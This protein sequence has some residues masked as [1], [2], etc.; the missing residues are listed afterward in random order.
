METRMRRDLHPM[1]REGLRGEGDPLNISVLRFRGVGRGTN[2][3]RADNGMTEI[4]RKQLELLDRWGFTT[5]TLSDYSLFLRGDL[6][7]PRRPII[8][9]FDGL[10]LLA[11]L[12]SP[13]RDV[14]GRAMVFVSTESL[15]GYTGDRTTPNLR[16]LRD[17]GIQVG[18][19]TCSQR[20]LASLTPC[21]RA[22]ELLRSR[23]TLEDL[24]G[25]PVESCAYPF[26]VVN[27]DVKRSVLEAGYTFGLAGPRGP[28]LFGTD[29]LEIRREVIDLTTGVFNLALRVFA[30][31]DRLI[32][33]RTRTMALVAR[34][35]THRVPGSIV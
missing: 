15:E 13:L 32:R 33:L 11:P 12:V 30:P 31:T 34:E 1:D 17:I 22:E 19:L 9:T 23:E 14:G 21:E 4:F 20:E 3:H 5:I 26:D 27:A 6:H 35:S 7:L 2:G 18:S 28:R 25:V 8:L 16:E 29:P 10:E 24:I